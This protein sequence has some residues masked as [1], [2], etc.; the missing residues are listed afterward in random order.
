MGNEYK[1]W[2]SD[3]DVKD[4]DRGKEVND[5]PIKGYCWH[6]PNVFRKLCDNMFVWV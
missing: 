5:P 3:E 4:E 6:I 2:A 1:G